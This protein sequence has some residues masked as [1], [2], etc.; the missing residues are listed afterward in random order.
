MG[1]GVAA[2]LATLR[3]VT[4]AGCVAT[5]IG[6]ALGSVI[7][8][9]DIRP[10]D[11]AKDAFRWRMVALVLVCGLLAYD[12]LH[13]GI[14]CTY[15]VDHLGLEVVYGVV[16]LVAT[17]VFAALS[18]HRTFSHSLVALALWC[19]SLKLLCE[20]LVPSFAIGV[21]THLL[22]D[23]T[24]KKGLRLF[25]PL[26]MEFSLGLWKSD[27]RI[28]DLFGLVGMAASVVLF[29]LFAAGRTSL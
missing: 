28:N 29:V 17:T 5:V 6:A 19:G 3:P 24:N 7:C 1:V 22:L 16:G 12:Y 26:G 20:P 23:L 15:V 13:A 14:V 10:S 18:P 21:A 9:V 11:K 25:W 27:G 4:T 2:A 8:D